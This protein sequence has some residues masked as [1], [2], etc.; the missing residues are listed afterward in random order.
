M[1]GGRLG[2]RRPETLLLPDAEPE[3]TGEVIAVIVP[4][5]IVSRRDVAISFLPHR[6]A[7]TQRSGGPKHPLWTRTEH[8]RRRTLRSCLTDRPATAAAQTSSRARKPRTT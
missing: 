4:P 5:Q 2:R 7:A 1:S 8:Q 3:W 6:P